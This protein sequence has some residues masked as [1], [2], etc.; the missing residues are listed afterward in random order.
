MLNS[1]IAS[2]TS[3]STFLNSSSDLNFSRDVIRAFI[4]AATSVDVNEWFCR[5]LVAMSDS[6]SILLS[7]FSRN[8]NLLFPISLILDYMV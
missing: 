1:S 5:P 2:S 6:W 4:V 8:K 3:L 7:A